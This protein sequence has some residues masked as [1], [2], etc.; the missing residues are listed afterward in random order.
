MKENR[1]ILI[2]LLLVFIIISLL[3]LQGFDMCDEGWVLTG[4][5]Q[6]F[7]APE[8]VEYMFLYYLTQ[9]LGGVW[10]KLFGFG[11]IYSFRILSA[12][13][14]AFTV[15]FIYLFNKN[16]L[17]SINKSDFVIG[18]FCAIICQSYGVM[19]F[20]HNYF[21]VLLAVLSFYLLLKS[22]ECLSWKL[23]LWSG[24]IMGLC[25]FVR[26]PNLILFIVV[27]LIVIYGYIIRKIYNKKLLLA[28]LFGILLGFLCVLCLMK[29]L[30]HYDIFVSSV[31]KGVFSAANNID[32]NH[33]VHDML[34]RYFINYKKVS[35][36][37]LY[38]YGALVIYLS[39]YLSIPTEKKH[40]IIRCI[41]NTIFL[42]FYFY[43]ICS[44]FRKEDIIFIAYGY[45]TGAL[46]IGSV[47]FYKKHQYITLLSVLLTILLLYGLPLGSD[48]GIYNMGRFLIWIPLPLS[49]HI[50]NR[51]LNFENKNI[52][53]A[54]VIFLLCFSYFGVKSIASQC[55]FDKGSRFEKTYIINNSL[56]TTLT[57][58]ENQKV[59]NEI[60]KVLSNY[61][62]KGDYVLFYQHFAT[63]YYL[64][65]TKPYLANPWPW[66]YDPEN[67]QKQFEKAEKRY[68]LP[69]LVWDKSSIL[70]W[71]E[72]YSDFDNE[73][74][75]ENYWHK[76]KRVM[77][78]KEFIKRHDYKLEWQNELFQ[79]W[80][81]GK[82][83][84]Y[85]S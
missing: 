81:P 78:I 71:P 28:L 7:A 40:Y 84:N 38:I 46:F 32:S 13:V 27:P 35:K 25:A 12:F 23:S 5:Q 29:I 8:S 4:Y 43:I 34:E 11:G 6:I 41:L 31:I 36:C 24:F 14:I 18:V 63:L 42:F 66:T 76:N 85:K 83:N 64:T 45:V 50:L 15:F 20:H 51:E 1:F 3:G 82:N 70:S 16:H 21:T 58:K 56:A 48:G 57:S 60:L 37:V 26:L 77:L 59:L 75:P 68:M 69:V 44:L 49:I 22:Y 17:H 39:I 33:N 72:T 30:G 10:N 79:I 54:N 73:N 61:I 9:L 2:T 80:I 62:K 53:I 55:Y 74:A 67:L 47:I 19:V 52:K 65:E